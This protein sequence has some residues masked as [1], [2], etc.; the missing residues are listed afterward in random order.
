[1]SRRVLLLA[2]LSAGCQNAAQSVLEPAGP[3]AAHIQ[4]L[5][6]LFLGVCTGVF[7]LVL[8]VLLGAVL[9]RRVDPSLGTSPPEVDAEALLPKDR[10]AHPHTRAVDPATEH[11]MARAVAVATGLTVLTLLWLLV[12]NTLTGKSLAA[13]RS[14]QALEIEV[15]SRQWWWEFKYRDPV[16]ARLLT[17]ANELHIPVGRPISLKL[18]SRD[19]IHSFWVP[20]LAGK[21][22]LIPGQENT[23]VLQA[24][25][26][27]VYRGLC[28]EFCGHQHAKMGFLVVAE[29]PEDFERWREH[30]LQ[31]AQPP[32]DA[33][34]QRGQQVFLTGPCVMCHAIQGT[35]AFATLGP[36]LTHLA[37]RQSLAANTVPNVRGHLAGWIL[38]AQSIKPGNKM[39]SISLPP[40]DLHALLAYLEGLK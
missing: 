20:S 14:P 7:V 38:N 2:L 5:G 28:A 32:A 34:A 26:P 10:L 18:N 1:M 13:M 11:R 36:N 31:P 3:H 16:P 37:S 35:D 9:R 4:G 29:P 22:D 39:P 19:V 27:G 30:Q 6:R 17:T 23:L 12:A 24:D 8:A 33:L 40:E 25:A 21:R 15:V